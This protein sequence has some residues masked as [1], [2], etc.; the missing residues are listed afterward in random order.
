M[1]KP[2]L[3]LATGIAILSWS[4]SFSQ[5]TVSNWKLNRGQ[6]TI[7][8]L[9]LPSHGAAMAYQY[10]SIPVKGDANWENAVLDDAGH[11][12]FSEPSKMT[13]NKSP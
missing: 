1:K 6:A 11:I 7:N 8:S 3:W 4:V 10:M 12:F 2:F 5:I 9:N 13:R